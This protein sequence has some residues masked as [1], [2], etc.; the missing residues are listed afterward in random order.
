MTRI[1]LA[2]FLVALAP[3]ATRAQDSATIRGTLTETVTLRGDSTQTAAIYLPP[4]C[5]AERKWPVLF[6]MDPRG[7]AMI[8]VD[9]FREAAERYG[10]IL[11]SS[12]NTLSDGPGE[13]NVAALNAMLGE[14][15]R[16]AVDTTRIYL[17]GFSGTARFGWFAALQLPQYIAGMFGAGASPPLGGSIETTLGG[18]RFAHF[19]AAGARDFNYQEVRELHDRLRLARIAHRTAFFDGPHS[20]PPDTLCA[21]GLRWL[22]LRAMLGGLRAVDSA[23]VRARIAEDIRDAAALEGARRMGDA[24]LAWRQIADDYPGWGADSAGKRAESLERRADVRRLR[25]AEMRALRRDQAHARALPATLLELRRGRQSPDQILD[26][27]DVPALRRE[28]ASR[29]SVAAA[30][31]QRLLERVYVFLA[32]YAPR[33]LEQAGAP[34]RALAMLEAASR[35]SPLG[36]ESCAIARR[37]AA[38]A[39][40]PLAEGCTPGAPE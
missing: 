24:A 34:A 10:Y 1:T 2:L 4:A 14:V 16:Y 19:G 6:L 37:V 28:S 18:T 27:L 21:R 11:I 8:P 22:E 7:R 30:E 26:R 17:A 38:A 12:Y 3:H 25:E 32:F 33:D 35:M 39:G 20:W 31:A 29:D 40:A 36:G 5:G 15:T 9:L 23:F 13:P